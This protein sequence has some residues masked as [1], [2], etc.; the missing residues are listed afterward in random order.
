MKHKTS[1]AR[2][3]LYIHKIEYFNKHKCF[4]KMNI[5]HLNELM[6]H[7]QIQ[8]NFVAQETINHEQILMLKSTD[9]IQ[10]RGK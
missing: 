3:T 7:E 2:S 6:N 8:R 1:Y 10:M 4:L 9:F 5:K